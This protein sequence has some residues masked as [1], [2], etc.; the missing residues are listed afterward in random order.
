MHKNER[1]KLIHRY[2]K[3]IYKKWIQ[4]TKGMSKRKFH[5]RLLCFV[6]AAVYFCVF[7]YF[8]LLLAFIL[9]LCAAI[10][11]LYQIPIFFPS[12]ILLQA[13][14]SRFSSTSFVLHRLTLNIH[15]RHDFLCGYPEYDFSSI[16]LPIPWP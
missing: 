1:K 11:L 15:H 6:Q 14:T 8:I 7:P 10:L 5:S 3:C 16:A 2:R 9:T 4:L 12:F 13:H